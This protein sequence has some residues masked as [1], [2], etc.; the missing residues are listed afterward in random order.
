M[1]ANQVTLL[2]V[3]VLLLV[4]VLAGFF[5]RRNAKKNAVPGDHRPHRPGSGYDPKEIV[6]L[7]GQGMA[8]GGR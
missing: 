2:M 4:F 8:H 5:L 6:N 7:K 1:S 3:P